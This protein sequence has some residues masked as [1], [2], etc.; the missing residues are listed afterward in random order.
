MAGSGTET[1]VLYQAIRMNAGARDFCCSVSGA[2]TFAP[3]GAWPLTVSGCY[4]TVAEPGPWL[5]E[6]SSTIPLRSTYR[7]LGHAIE[8]L[9]V[10]CPDEICEDADPKLL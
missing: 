3:N 2:Q 6:C 7:S 4:D 8:T 5:A 9:W 10:I 1:T